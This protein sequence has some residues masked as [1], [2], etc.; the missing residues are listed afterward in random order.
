MDQSDL[1]R[2]IIRLEQLASELIR[3]NKLLKEK[4]GK[5]EQERSMI[6]GSQGG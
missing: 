1:E 3:I 2:R 5:L 4:V 6:R